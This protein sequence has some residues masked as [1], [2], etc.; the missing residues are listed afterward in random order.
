MLAIK[1]GVWVLYKEK[2]PTEI[3]LFYITFGKKNF[4]LNK[5]ESKFCTMKRCLLIG[6]FY[7]NFGKKKFWTQQGHRKLGINCLESWSILVKCAHFYPSLSTRLT[8]KFP[9]ISFC[10]VLLL[11]LLLL[12]WYCWFL[13]DSP[14]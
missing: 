6:L 1:T 12:F 11:L 5:G 9:H 3:G 2:E 10:L 13:I 8:I 7:I 4:E 14:V